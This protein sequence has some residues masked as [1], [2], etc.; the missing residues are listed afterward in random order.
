MI[1]ETTLDNPV[2]IR[3]MTYKL[4]DLSLTGQKPRLMGDD[5]YYSHSINALV[6]DSLFGSRV[7]PRNF[8]WLSCSMDVP[9]ILIFVLSINTLDVFYHLVKMV[10]E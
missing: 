9:Y 4:Y 2:A 6:F 1:C 8:G 7:M 10:K 3:S 5:F